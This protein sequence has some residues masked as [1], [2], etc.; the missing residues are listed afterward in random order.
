M[1]YAVSDVD[2]AILQAESE[3]SYFELH[4][5]ESGLAV[6][7]RVMGLRTISPVCSRGTAAC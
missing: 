1:V 3:L 2:E 5:P 6:Q 7:I 4:Q